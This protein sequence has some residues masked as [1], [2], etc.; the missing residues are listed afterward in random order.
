MMEKFFF[1]GDKFIGKSTLLK[2]CLRYS[3]YSISGFYVDRLLNE[4]AEITGFV[5]RDAKALFKTEF[6][7]EDCKEHCFLKIENGQRI[8]NLAV[9][10]HFGTQLLQ[11]A[12]SNKSE[13]VL[14]DEIGGMELLIPN[15]TG[16]LME[17]MTQRRKILGVFKS[18]KNYQR[19]RRNSLEKLN[20]NDQ[21]Q[22]LREQIYLH[23]GDILELT[24]KNRNQCEKKLQD[25]LMQ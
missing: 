6:G 14:L 13:I 18:D 2:K 9:F 12:Q 5:L 11:E 25:F 19:Q 22:K 20:I 8:R 21:R 16:E 4:K 10:E 17:L 23:N 15:F 3:D 24:E 7:Q 1:E